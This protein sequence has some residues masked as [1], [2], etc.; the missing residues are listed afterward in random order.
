MPPCS[1]PA[2]PRPGRGRQQPGQPVLG[3]AVLGEDHDPLVVPVRRPAGRSRSSS[4]DQGPGLG[5]RLR[6]VAGGP[7]LHA[8]PAAPTPSSSGVGLHRPD[9]ARARPRSASASAARRRSRS[10]SRVM[11]SSLHPLPGTAASRWL[12]RGVRRWWI[13]A[14]CHGL[15]VD[16]EVCANAAGRRTAASSAAAATRSVPRPRSTAWRGGGWRD[17]RVSSGV[18]RPLTRRVVGPRSRRTRR[19]NRGVPS[20]FAM[21]SFSRRTITRGP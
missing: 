6:L 8:L 4:L 18:D 5:V 2:A 21:S 17:T 15:Q 14:W 10:S 19:G 1:R 7:G 11:R 12:G 13:G 20:A 16:L 3:V 9:S